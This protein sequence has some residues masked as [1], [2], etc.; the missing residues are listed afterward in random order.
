MED[1][2]RRPQSIKA[3]IDDTA[4]FLKT[5][6]LYDLD[7]EKITYGQ[8]KSLILNIAISLEDKGLLQK[9]ILIYSENRYEYEL[10]EMAILYA[11]GTVL[12]LDKELS[13]KEVLDA[14]KLN[15]VG[16]IFT[17][18]A[19]KSKVKNIVSE[20]KVFDFDS[21]PFKQMLEDKDDSRKKELQKLK[22]NPLA[23]SLI[24]FTSGTTGKSKSVALSQGAI[25]NN[26]YFSAEYV[27]TNEKDNVL[28]LM[29]LSH[30]LEG[31]F[32]L[33]S[34]IY[35]G[36]RRYHSKGIENV[37]QEINKYKITFMCAVPV[38]Y[39]YLKD[40]LEEIENKEILFFCAGAELNEQTQKEFI[41]K[42]F[43]LIQGYG[44][45]ESG[46][47][48]SLDSKDDY[49]VGSCGKPLD[50]I[51]L[52]I[53]ND[54]N[55][56]YGA[57]YIRSNSMFN[58]YIG[59]NT[60]DYIKDG[61]FNTGDLA[62]F[63]KDGYLYISGRSKDVIVLP[64][65]QKVIPNEIEK[66]V[67]LIEEVRE[68][69]IY[70]EKVSD[71]KSIVAAEINCNARDKEIIQKK[72][73]ELNQS[74]ADFEKITKIRFTNRSL[75]KATS[76]KET[77]PTNEKEKTKKKKATG[78][79]PLSRREIIKIIKEIIAKQLG[80]TIAKVKND[81]DLK[82]ELIADSFDKITIITKIEKE[83]KLQIDR[84]LYKNLNSVKT[85]VDYVCEKVI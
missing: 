12:L 36:T 57:L 42:G 58:G 9:P 13:N 17:S 32:S 52:K 49:R 8:A 34:S 68:V 30:S 37:I 5:N 24:L 56:E 72:I 70:E 85:L 6:I 15:K 54:K 1:G 39:E 4:L 18:K 7:K 77:L 41:N 75:K 83:F 51:D 23:T 63:D 67:E 48:I 74:L 28:S 44:M 84:S 80:I 61:W 14:C 27:R 73:D 19:L 11:G 60:T 66:K 64:T 43:T 55:G 38:V 10:L 16:S 26:L 62:R 50:N 79:E 45:T 81:A 29:P 33:Y 53:E 82:T 47:A 40:H 76:K 25:C 65:G 46:P 35:G 59:L 71:N 3:L 20:S 78:K 31:I 2:R 69:N 22:V 21:N